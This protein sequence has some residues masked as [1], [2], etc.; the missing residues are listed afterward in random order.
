MKESIATDS[1]CSMQK[2]GMHLRSPSSTADDCHRPLLEAIRHEIMQRAQA[3]DETILLK[4]KSHI[5]IYGN[6]MADKLANKAAYECCMN[7]H[8]DHDLS[9]DY[10]HT[11]QIQTAEGPAETKACIRGLDDH[12]SLIKALHDKHKLGQSKQDSLYFQLWDKV[13]PVRVKPHS[14]ALWTMPS[15]PESHKRSIF[16]YRTGQLWNKNIAFQRRMPYMPGQPIAK[17]TRCPLCRGDDSQGH[18]FGSCMHPDMSKQY[19]ARHDKAMR[20]VVQAFTKGQCG[21]HYLI[22]DVGKFEGLT[23]Q[24]QTP[25]ETMGT[26]VQLGA[27][28]AQ[29]HNY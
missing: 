28:T 5:G 27:G 14:D 2:N 25:N 8:F 24:P 13:Q 10:T 4:V 3:G 21:S 26:S 9:N 20:T 11:I 19:I 12:G 1:K 18:I 29:C 6:E 15:I 22:A 23:L 17:D 16:K 7:R